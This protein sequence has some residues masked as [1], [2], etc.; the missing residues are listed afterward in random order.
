MAS[1]YMN[2]EHLALVKNAYEFARD[3]HKEQFRKSGEPYIIHTIQVAGILVELKMDPSTVASGFL[4]DV[5]EDTTVTL[6]DLEEV[7]G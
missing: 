1:H 7:F 5:V 3:S 2:Q 6:A 4:H